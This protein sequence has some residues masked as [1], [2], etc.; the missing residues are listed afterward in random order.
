MDESNENLLDIKDDLPKKFNIRSLDEVQR[1]SKSDNNKITS[2]TEIASATFGN[3]S[4]KDLKG[5]MI[6]KEP[7]P[8]FSGTKMPEKKIVDLNGIDPTTPFIFCVVPALMSTVGY[9]GSKYMG[10]HFA[11]EFLTSDLYPVQRM[12]TVARNI[13]V[14]IFMLGTG[15]SGVVSIGLFFLGIAVAT[16]V[17]KGELDPNKKEVSP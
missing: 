3:L 2:K 16:G 8:Y 14:G 9:F 7:Q 4:I 6:E 15:F 1:S 12:A 11:V 17:A 13:I 10:E 5:R